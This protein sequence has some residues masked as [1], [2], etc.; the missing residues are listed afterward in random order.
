MRLADAARALG[1]RLEQTHPHTGVRRRV[2]WTAPAAVA[3]AMVVAV[4][5]A[6]LP[7]PSDPAAAIDAEYAEVDALLA[8]VPQ[9]DWDEGTRRDFREALAGVDRAIALSRDAVRRSPRNEAFRDLCRLAY[10]AK[11]RLIEAHLSRG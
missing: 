9:N 2:R 7:R 5:A 10:R 3:V 4:V 8:R 1:A 6:H 11:R